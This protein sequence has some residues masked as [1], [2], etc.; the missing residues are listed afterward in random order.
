MRAGTGSDATFSGMDEL[1][2]AQLPVDLDNS[3]LP[4]Y[5]A[6]N[7]LVPRPVPTGLGSSVK[8]VGLIA[9]TLTATPSGLTLDD[10]RLR[11]RAFRGAF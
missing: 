7:Q 8:G 5:D 3:F 1:D 6:N 10:S 4:V 11:R 9:G 2:P